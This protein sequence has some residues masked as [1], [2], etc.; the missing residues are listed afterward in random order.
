MK[1]SIFRLMKLQAPISSRD[2]GNSAGNAELERV[3]FEGRRGE[4]WKIGSGGQHLHYL[5]QL[6]VYSLY[7]QDVDYVVQEGKVIIVDGLPVA[8]VWPPLPED[9]PGDRG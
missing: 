5:H 1:S 3:G 9:S 8:H 6:L 2:T 7:E 4:A